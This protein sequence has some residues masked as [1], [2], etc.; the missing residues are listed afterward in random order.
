MTK[1]LATIGP[2]TEDHTNLKK[3]LGTTNLVR[4]NGAHNTIKW[5]EKIS[6]RIKKIN[7]NT[8]ILLDL[9]GI[10]PRSLNKDNIKIKKNENLFF[11]YGKYKNNN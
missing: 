4:L 2:A 9:P 8:K 1:I 11:T 6:K 10:K 3:V 7:P 5:H